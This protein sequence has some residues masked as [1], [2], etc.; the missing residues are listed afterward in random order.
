MFP[1]IAHSGVASENLDRSNNKV[2]SHIS[3]GFLF[4]YYLFTDTKV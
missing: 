2:S 3:Y 1:G 4:V